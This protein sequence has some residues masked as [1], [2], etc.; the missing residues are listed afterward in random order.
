MDPPLAT[1]GTV[2]R[3]KISLQTRLRGLPQAIP[4][5]LP[6]TMAAVYQHWYRL[7]FEHFGDR[8]SMLTVS[9]PVEPSVPTHVD[10]D[11]VES[12]PSAVELIVGWQ[13]FLPS[14]P[15][16]ADRLVEA[17]DFGT[18]PV[19]SGHRG[20]P[21]RGSE[22][23]ELFDEP[24]HERGLL[25]RSPLAIPLDDSTGYVSLVERFPLA[26]PVSPDHPTPLANR[27]S[28]FED[29]S[30][31]ERGIDPPKRERL[32]VGVSRRQEPSSN[33]VPI[34]QR[35]YWDRSTHRYCDVPSNRRGETATNSVP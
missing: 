21:P 2:H 8:Q 19:E 13:R 4:N 18:S 6:P 9:S 1:V 10:G 14:V 20:V 32:G 28:G 26:V 7:E 11:F 33:P 27:R 12:R 34:I 15:A 16:F 23:V 3:G 22:S 25:P 5:S 35:I 17:I 24:V 30:F 31:D 29:A